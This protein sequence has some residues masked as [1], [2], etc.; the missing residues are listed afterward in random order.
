MGMYT[1]LI[2]GCGLKKET[3]KEVISILRYMHDNNEFKSERNLII[4]RHTLFG[5]TRWRIMFQCSSYYFGVNQGYSRIWYD[6][7]S[8]NWRISTRSN[9]KNYNDEIE[10]FLDWIKPWI[11]QGS[12][13]RGLYAIVMYEESS[14]PTLYYLDES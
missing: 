1:E 14:S 10:L 7:I 12:G 13:S 3:P 6:G 11:S 9:L 2:F 8:N 5:D 4:P